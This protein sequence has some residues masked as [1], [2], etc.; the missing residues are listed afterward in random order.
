MTILT[1]ALSP[2]HQ[3]LPAPPGL[4]IHHPPIRWN[5]NGNDLLDG[6]IALAI[7]V[8]PHNRVPTHFLTIDGW[9]KPEAGFA[10]TV[11]R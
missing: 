7:A 10:V 6:Q 9:A 4:L 3:I 8:W 11:K 5:E 1:G 2:G